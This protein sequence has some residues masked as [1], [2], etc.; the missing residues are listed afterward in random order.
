M[1][2]SRLYKEFAS[3]LARMDRKRG[4]EVVAREQADVDPYFN[5]CERL[6][7][8]RGFMRSLT[9]SKTPDRQFDQALGDLTTR[10]LSELG[11]GEYPTL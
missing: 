5:E 9:N 7:I 1:T 8:L 11:F 6:K 2:Y 4:A 10:A 3:A